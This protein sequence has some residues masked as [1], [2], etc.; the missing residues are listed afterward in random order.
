MLTTHYWLLLSS[1]RD[2]VARFGGFVGRQRPAG[3]LLAFEAER[4]VGLHECVYVARALVDYRGP[5]FAQ[6]AFD[7][8]VFLIAVRTVNLNRHRRGFLAATGRLPLRQARRARVRTP[9]VLEPA[10]LE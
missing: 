3:R 2:G 4:P 5:A 9:I 10:G 1:R 8:I 6:I 7:W